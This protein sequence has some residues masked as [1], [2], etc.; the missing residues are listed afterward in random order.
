MVQQ[1]ITDCVCGDLTAD[2]HSSR[3]KI[4]R[5]AAAENLCSPR[6]T[7]GVYMHCTSRSTATLHV[8]DHVWAAGNCM[9]QAIQ[10]QTAHCVHMQHASWCCVLT[11]V[12]ASLSWA[13]D[14]RHCDCKAGICWHSPAGADQSHA[15]LQAFHLLNL[16]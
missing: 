9:L 7:A 12:L 13:G 16:G 8:H 6:N 1:M 15:A 2:I 4:Q 5:T 14:Q 3:L 10:K 11:H